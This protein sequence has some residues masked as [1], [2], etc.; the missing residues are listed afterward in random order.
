MKGGTDGMTQFIRALHAPN[1]DVICIVRRPAVGVAAQPRRT[2]PIANP[3]PVAR[4]LHQQI[5][6]LHS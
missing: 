1:I 5:L 3:S 6:G 2:R 4:R